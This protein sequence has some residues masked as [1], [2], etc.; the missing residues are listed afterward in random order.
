MG[1][2]L[3]REMKIKNS[4]IRI[5]RIVKN[6]NLIKKLRRIKIILDNLSSSE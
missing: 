6:Q 2:I 5:L 4:L 1:F 3:I